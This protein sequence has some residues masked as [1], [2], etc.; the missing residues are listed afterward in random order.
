MLSLV[1]YATPS[2]HHTRQEGH[3]YIRTGAE[4]V[5]YPTEHIRFFNGNIYWYVG[6]AEKMWKMFIDR[7]AAMCIP[8]TWAT[9]LRNT[10]P[11][12]FAFFFCRNSAILPLSQRVCHVRVL[13]TC[14]G[15]ARRDNTNAIGQV[16]QHN[17]FVREEMRN[18]THYRE[19]E[20][21]VY[22]PKL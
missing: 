20:K 16:R 7:S 3:M 21:E 11:G 14:F 10:H 17:T 9:L 22:C 4:G 19:F 1:H 5:P 13:R 2:T 6:R 15:E 18:V 8:V 12:R